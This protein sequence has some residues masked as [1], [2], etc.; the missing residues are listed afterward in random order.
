MIDD[1]EVIFLQTLSSYQD[2]G[3]GAGRSRVFLA[4]LSRSRLRKKP[5]ARAAPKKTRSRSRKKYAAP[6]PTKFG[7]KKYFTKLNK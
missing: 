6:V 1:L 2:W 3:A 4:P 7:E 5:G